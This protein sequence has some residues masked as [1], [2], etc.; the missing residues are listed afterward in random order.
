VS[1]RTSVRCISYDVKHNLVL[2]GKLVYLL[3][4][5]STTYQPDDG[6]TLWPK[7][8][9]EV[10]FSKYTNFPSNT[11]LCLTSHDIHITRYRVILRHCQLYIKA[12]LVTA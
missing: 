4:V 8:V 7:H 5:T 2:D 10:T 12:L 9:V 3:N 11:K 1:N 6:R